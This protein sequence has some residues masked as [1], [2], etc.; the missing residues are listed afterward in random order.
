[1]ARPRSNPKIDPYEDL[2][3]D[4]ELRRHLIWHGYNP[5]DADSFRP[6]LCAWLVSE[7][8]H[9]N[10]SDIARRTGLS[11]SFLHRTKQDAAGR[12][13]DHLIRLV[14]Y[15]LS[16]PLRRGQGGRVRLTD[17][18]RI[19]VKSWIRSSHA[20]LWALAKASGIHYK[21]LWSWLHVKC[22]CTA[23]PDEVEIVNNMM[24]QGPCPR[25]VRQM[26]RCDRH[27]D[28]IMAMIRAGVERVKI[29]ETI[30]VSRSLLSHWMRRRGI[31]TGRRDRHL[32]MVKRWDERAD[33]IIALYEK[34][35]RRGAAE[36][37]GCAPDTIGR[38]M[39][40]QRQK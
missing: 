16:D 11:R 18:W 20:S 36:R 34:H 35:G 26:D 24:A 23:N 33:E 9:R 29:A 5:L 17:A 19:Q 1:M 8:G 10:I 6:A 3:K 2:R 40:R 21:T 15:L 27:L 31:K 7:L 28:G 32:H 13:D 14:L 39:T 22:R 25:V 30:G 37:L 38:W 12:P 4:A